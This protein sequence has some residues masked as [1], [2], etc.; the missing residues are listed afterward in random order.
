VEYAL[1]L[2][3]IV[4]G[5]IAVWQGLGTKVKD[6]VILTNDAFPPET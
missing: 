5:A 3:L 6:S 4:V 1:L 2:A